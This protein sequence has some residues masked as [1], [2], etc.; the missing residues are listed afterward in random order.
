MSEVWYIFDRISFTLCKQSSRGSSGHCSKWV[1]AWVLQVSEGMIEY[2]KDSSLLRS[3]H[4]RFGNLVFDLLAVDN[5]D[6]ISLEKARHI[7]IRP[8]NCA[9]FLIASVKDSNSLFMPSNISVYVKAAYIIVWP[10]ITKA[11]EL[12]LKV[13]GLAFCGVVS[14]FHYCYMYERHYWNTHVDRCYETNYLTWFTPYCEGLTDH[15]LYVMI[16]MVVC[17][18]YISFFAIPSMCGVKNGCFHH[19]CCFQVY[20]ARWTHTQMLNLCCLPKGLDLLAF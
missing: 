11:N 5:R 1:K 17:G 7:A 6:P 13:V 3:A 16:S 14:Y 18:S 10:I 12:P 19:M 20:Y 15:S 4:V 2:C 8:D 9:S